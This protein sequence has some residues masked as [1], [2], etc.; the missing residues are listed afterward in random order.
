MMDGVTPL[1]Y[2]P[3]AGLGHNG[4]PPLEDPVEKVFVDTFNEVV[5]ECQDAVV[6]PKELAG[7]KKPASW[8]VMPRWVMLLVGRVMSMGAAKYG[9]FNYR[10]SS[11]SAS[12]YQDAMERHL[13]LW[14]DGEDTDE[15]SGVSH[16]AHVIASCSLLLDAQRTGKLNDDRQKT[17][18]ARK[19]LDEIEAM[20]AN[21]S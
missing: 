10:D 16:L 5:A 11:I 13:Q 14:F 2:V 15:E 18:I 4:G 6:N 12:I 20:I 17:G 3:P 8:S 7:A 9:A 21:Q 1:P 19:V